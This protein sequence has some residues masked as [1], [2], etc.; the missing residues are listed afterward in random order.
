[1]QSIFDDGTILY[2]GRV[3]SSLCGATT[4]HCPLLASAQ[5]RHRHGGDIVTNRP[6]Y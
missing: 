6:Y 3:T 4:L 5:N 1:M 2:R